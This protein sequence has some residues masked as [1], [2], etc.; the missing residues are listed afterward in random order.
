MDL[1]VTRVHDAE[2]AFAIDD[3]TGKLHWAQIRD[4]RHGAPGCACGERTR[5]Q[6]DHVIVTS[7]NALTPE[8]HFAA[9]KLAEVSRPVLAWPCEQPRKPLTGDEYGS[10]WLCHQRAAKIAILLKFKRAG[11]ERM[12]A[13]NEDRSD[14]GRQED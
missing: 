5:Q 1:A 12:L 2:V 14:T 8:L 10:I 3:L 4:L 6:L 9:V 13:C 11:R 7:K